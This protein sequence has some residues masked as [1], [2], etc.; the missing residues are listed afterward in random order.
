M[1][2]NRPLAGLSIVNTRAS[3]QAKPLTAELTAMGTTVLHYPAIRIGPPADLAPLDSA[4]A[5]LVQ[6]EF[7]W[8]I[9]TST[10]TVEALAQRL[11]A[12][13]TTNPL[14]VPPVRVASI[15]PATAEAAAQR[16]GVQ[17]ALLPEKFVAESLAS[18]LALQP[19]ERVLLPQSSIARPFLAET[20]QASGADVTQVIAY[21]TLTGQGGDPVPQLFWEGRIDAVTFTSPSTVHNFL[22]RLKAEGGNASMLVDVAVA[23]IGPQTAAAAVSHDLPRPIEAEE[24]TVQGLVQALIRYF[25]E[26]SP[27]IRAL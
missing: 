13:G 9:L 11:T 26:G 24:F 14:A 23:C 2:H 21:R 16:L 12:G 15:G 6:G 5:A 1:P 7:D 22:K 18:T 8:L 10:N 17:T 25:H 27:K 4:L 19:G 20:F 3:H